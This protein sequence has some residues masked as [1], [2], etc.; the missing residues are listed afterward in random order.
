MKIENTKKYIE[1][2]IEKMKTIKKGVDVIHLSYYKGLLNEKDIDE[3]HKVLDKINL[4]LSTYDK[5]G[6]LTASLDDFSLSVFYILSE[7]T[8]QE[9]LN[10]TIT[11]AT[12]DVIKFIVINSWNKVKN[13]TLT[14]YTSTSKENKK[15]SFGVKISIDK[16]THFDFHLDGNIDEA[17]INKALDKILD[18]LHKQ[19][20]NKI[21]KNAN[22]VEYNIKKNEW[23]ST[24]FSDMIKKIKQKKKK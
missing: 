20:K 24:E 9:I 21:Y 7:L 6:D 17:T 16:N 11:N 3:Y 19:Q 5:N 10:G 18:F 12:W 23:K 22:Y 4:K 1:K 14:K 2:R 8:I 13:K 15:V